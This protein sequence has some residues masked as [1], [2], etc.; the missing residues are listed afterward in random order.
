MGC[1]LLFRIHNDIEGMARS[2]RNSIVFVVDDDASVRKGLSRLIASAGYAVQA[3]ASANEFLSHIR[4]QEPRGCVVLDLRMPGLNGLE[5]QHRLKTISPALPI[6]FITGHGTVPT[7]VQAMREG[8]VHFLT[9]PVND[10]ALL[11]VIEQSISKNATEQDRIGEL[12]NLQQRA[13]TLTPR[14]HEVMV[15]VVRGRLN[16]Q[17][18]AE[19]GTVEKTIKVHRARVLQKMEVDSL[20]DLVRAAEKLGIFSPETGSNPMQAVASPVRHV[21]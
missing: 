4:Q 19:L 13:G 20:A 14:E 18:A 17:I 15:L 6:I 11:S 1:L 5:L 2:E 12:R 3:F 8:A 21:V 10:Q 16:K 9:K 7:S